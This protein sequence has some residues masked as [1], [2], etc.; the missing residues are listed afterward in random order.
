MDVGLETSLI[1]TTDQRTYHMR[2]RSHRTQYMPQVAFTYPEDALAKWDT[3][4]KR[5]VQEREKITI[6]QTGEYL[7]NL[8]FEYDVDG[9]APW[10]PV[11]VYSDGKK[12]IIQ[13]PK[14]MSQ[15]EAPSL[16]VLRE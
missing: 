7:G 3:I 13:M 11:R 1:V 4:R 10:K 12:T 14:V 15:T 6:P 2:L 16:L 8:D 9:D 5:E